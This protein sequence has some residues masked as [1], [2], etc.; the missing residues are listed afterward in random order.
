MEPAV[1]LRVGVG[2]VAGVHDRALQRR[3]QPD[4]LLEE[5][6]PLRQLEGHVGAAHRRHL[7]PHLARAGVD[8]AAHE[9][10][11]HVVHDPA[12]RHRP[13]HQVV[14]MG[15]VGVALAVGVV[16]Q[17]HHVLPRGQHRSRRLHRPGEYALPRLVVPNALEGV[18]ALRR[19]VLGVG[20]VDV[21]ASA[22]REDGVDQVRLDLGGHRTLAC[23]PPRVAP[24]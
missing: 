8:L 4:L 20:V 7:R 10:G 16:L 2:L 11:H 21:V 18:R 24:G 13:V 22:V 6:G 17:D 15:A 23:E 19:G 1:L 5:V 12:E 14:L 3:L 9:M